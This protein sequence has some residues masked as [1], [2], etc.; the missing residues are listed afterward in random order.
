MIFVDHKLFFELSK[1]RCQKVQ[2]T[3]QAPFQL[4]LGI[5]SIFVLLIFQIKCAPAILKYNLQWQAQ[6]IK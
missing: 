1:I 2:N 4:F 6:E 3:E 5:F